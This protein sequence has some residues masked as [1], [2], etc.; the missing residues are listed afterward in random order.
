[1]AG[2]FG[3]DVLDLSEGEVPEA[4]ES[5]LV[6]DEPASE[7]DAESAKPDDPSPEEVDASPEDAFA[8]LFLR[9]SVL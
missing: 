3:V 1:L 8:E 9:L 4:D 5:P 2:T 7:L 6:E